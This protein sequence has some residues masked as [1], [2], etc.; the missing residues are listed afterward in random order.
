M[1]IYMI[2]VSHISSVHHYNDSRIVKRMLTSLLSQ[3]TFRVKWI[4]QQAS[5]SDLPED[6]CFDLPCQ[7]KNMANDMFVSS[8]LSLCKYH[9]I[10]LLSST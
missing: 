10:R 4:A 8:S 6:V 3:K 2:E 5:L 1:K 9:E 7:R